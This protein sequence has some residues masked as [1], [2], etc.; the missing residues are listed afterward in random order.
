MSTA[1]RTAAERVAELRK[2]LDYHSHRYYVLDDPEISDTE[3]DALLNEL[4]DLEAEH[5]ELLTPDSPTQRVGAEPLDKF[6]QVRHPQ[7][8]LSLANARNQ[9]ELEA[10]VLRSERYLAR[11]GV[12]LGEVRFV[13][14]PKIDGLAVS[15]VYEDGRFVRG[16]TRGNGEV[17]EDVTQNLR[18]IKAIPLR[19]EGAPRL[20][21][22]RG[23][24]YLPLAAFARLNEQRAA[25]G[26][27]TYAN[28]RNTAA[29][30][31][32]QLDPQ[33]AA[34][35]PLSIWC[36][37]V[38]AVE[39]LEFETH[40]E[41]L[42]W[43]RD[44]GF[45]VS[46]DVGVHDTV[47]EVVA[48]CRAWE[49]RRDRLDYEIDGVVV[50]VD[51]LSLQR[52]LG[53]VGREP[54]GAIAWKFAPTTATTTLKEVS[55]NVGRTGH[56]VPFAVLEPVQVSGVTVKLATLHN[57]EDL[58]RKDVRAGDEVI[59]M[60]AGDVIPQV[61]SPTAKAQRAKDRGPVPEPPAE[62]PMCGTPT[63]KPE[64]GVWTICPNRTGCPGQVFQAVK[65]FVGAIDIDGLGEENV[66]R[67]LSEGLI[68]SFADLY[69]L[70]VERLVELD[71]FGEVSA[72]N[73][74]HSI[75]AS[76]GQPFHLVLYA[77]GIPGIGFVNAR[78]LARHFR[79]MGA[80]LEASEPELSGVEGMGEIMAR[81]VHE[82]L[83]EERTRALIER[84]RGYGL[85]MEDEG[86]APPAEGPL[87]GKTLVLT[88]TLPN[89]PR[90]DAA[91]LIE[92]AG[93]KVTG[94]VSKKTDY[95]VVGDDPGGT[96]YTKA[97]ELGIEM[98]DE[99]GLLEL[100]PEGVPAPAAAPPRRR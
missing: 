65:H 35:R 44:H 41:W 88:G 29:G 33:L 43:L 83:S 82:T 75:E 74:V 89:L 86:P 11:Q 31:I 100:V 6:E 90:E 80:L 53:V 7:V 85:Q 96:K 36:Y 23:E 79:S 45:R 3:Y 49:E 72:T 5:P 37:G 40:H 22:V 91:R 98:L 57:E 87:V 9:E 28:P 46:R 30:S 81:T 68:E 14:E 69:D 8:M 42:D 64:G 54:R 66:R 32:R 51:D 92:A 19:V 34:S 76:K 48:A 38:G 93:G 67:F 24:A 26:E 73:L 10:W 60:R 58:R 71:G 59:V 95:V 4:R 78:N 56:M 20:L 12:E 17:G 50:K 27:P 61:V 97:Q 25:A 55:W 47:E 2:Q 21:E 94:S 70:T 18:T 63:V 77:L 52:Q 1:E 39:G 16:A 15:L 13:T 84:L 62:C 99:E